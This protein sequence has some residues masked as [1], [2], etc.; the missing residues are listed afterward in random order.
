MSLFSERFK[1]LKE[2]HHL[3]LKELSDGLNISIPNLSYYMKGREPNYDILINISKYFGV[4]T[5]WLIGA[6]DAQDEIQDILAYQIEDC[7]GFFSIAAESPEEADKLILKGEDRKLYLKLQK[8]LYDTMTELYSMLRDFNTNFSNDDKAL[9]CQLLLLTIKNFRHFFFFINTAI[10]SSY[11]NKFFTGKNDIYEF[12]NYGELSSE[13][14]HQLFIQLLYLFGKSF[15][16]NT[17][18]LSDT[19]RALVMELMEYLSSKNKTLYPISRL[20]DI[21]NTL[22]MQRFD[23]LQKIYDYMTPEEIHTQ[24]D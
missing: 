12:L 17:N 15:S 5:D 22:S 18:A 14:E 1:Q 10:F 3:T 23:M 24:F 20:L 11:E 9:G 6:T 13:L 8:E 16:D 21:D 19:D 2:E 7:E 4:T